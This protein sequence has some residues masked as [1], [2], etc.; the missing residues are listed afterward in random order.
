MIYVYRRRASDSARDLAE[1]MNVNCRRLNDLGRAHFGN[2]VRAGDVV[3][4]W[5]EALAPINGVKIL[6][7]AGLTNKMED[8]RLLRAANVPTVEVS[9]TRPPAVPANDWV[10][11]QAARLNRDN[12][13]RVITQ[14]QAFLATPVPV[15]MTWLARRFNHVGGAD[16]LQPPP[17]PDYFSKKEDLREEYRIHCFDGKSIR[18]GVKVPREGTQP[19]AWIRSLDGG[20]RIRYDEFA[21]KKAMRELAAQAVAALGLQFGAVDIGKKADNSLIVLEVNR[22]PGLEGNTTTVYANAIETWL[23]GE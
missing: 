4:C 23:K 14:L 18:A 2:G 10:E 5:G 22:A 3:I 17:Q 15:P 11:F 6:N 7:G 1:A 13:R 16:L 9:Q 20:W 12:A 21:S 8:A 19:H